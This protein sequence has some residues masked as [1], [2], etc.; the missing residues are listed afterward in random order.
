MITLKRQIGNLGEKLAEE[1]LK[2]KGYKVIGRN[3]FWRGGE[4][5]LIAEDGEA[6][7]F[8]EVKTRIEIQ[9]NCHSCPE[10]AVD[11]S[12]QKKLFKT[13]QK[14]LQ[15]YKGS[16]KNYR[17]DVISIEIDKKTRKVKIRQFENVFY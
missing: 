1:Y 10:K 16:L 4:I 15:D 7:V 6:L 12:K 2:K 3:Y 5:D 14:Y 13:A 8:I 9:C 17:L 11:Y